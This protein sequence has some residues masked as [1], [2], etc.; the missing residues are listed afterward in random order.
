MVEEFQ[1][2]LRD[3]AAN[4]DLHESVRDSSGKEKFYK[5]DKEE[6]AHR[7]GIQQMATEVANEILDQTFQE[8]L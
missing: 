1:H 3:K 8:R 4:F 5:V 2:L 7:T 6:V